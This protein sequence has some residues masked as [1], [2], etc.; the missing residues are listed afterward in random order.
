MKIKN[1]YISSLLLVASLVGTTSCNDF[2]ERDLQGTSDEGQTISPDNVDNLVIAAYAH[3]VSGEDMNSPFSLWPYGNV[4]ADDAYNGGANSEDG[5]HFHFHFLEIATGMTTDN[6]A[7]DDIWYR[8]YSGVARANAALKSLDGMDANTY[9]QKNERIGE[10]RFLRGHYMFLLKVMFKHIVYVDETIPTSD[11]TKISNRQY[12]NDQLWQKIAD[13]FK[14]AYDHLPDTQV[15]KGRPT[16]AAASAYLAKVML[17]KAYRQNEKNEVT[18]INE[19][20]LKVVITYTDNA[21]MT[22]GGFGLEEDFAYNFLPQYE[23]GKESIWAVQYSQD[24]NTMYGN[25]NFGNELTAP[26][27]F[28]CCD[29]QKPSQNLVNAFRTENG[30]PMFDTYNE[31]DNYDVQGNYDPRLFHTVAIPGFPYKYNVN[32]IFDKTWTRNEQEYYGLYSSLKENVDPD[33]SCLKKVN[34][35]FVANSMNRIV[36]RYADVVLMRAEALIQLNRLSE[37]LPLVNEIRNRAA[38]STTL[39][40]DYGASFKVEPYTMAEWTDR[41]IAMRDLKWERRLELALEGSR[42]FD[43]VRWGDAAKVMNQYYASEAS[44]RSYYSD[45]NFTAGK[46]EY[47]PIPQKQINYSGGLYQQNNGWEK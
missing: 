21:I 41:D 5:S 12:T 16:Q 25:L 31:K 10:M 35:P 17:Y 13:D 47:L 43:L 44:R 23:N 1:I 32:Y 26:Q 11:Y 7:F 8:L 29:F 6:W 40:F 4:R 42:F 36:L 19:D 39:V 38:R 9:P 45:A 30:R 3:M 46:N 34:S 18:E 2:L 20:D 15:E 28:G 14:F 37:A 33:C 22:A 24:D 27:F